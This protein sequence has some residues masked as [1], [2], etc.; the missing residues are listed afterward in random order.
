MAVIRKFRYILT[1]FFSYI[2][3]DK[4][5]LKYEI[6]RPLL[7]TNVY[8]KILGRK[9]MIWIKYI[10]YN[11]NQKSPEFRFEFKNFYFGLCSTLKLAFEGE[12]TSQN[13]LFFVHT[14]FYFT[15]VTRDIFQ[16]VFTEVLQRNRG[17]RWHTRYLRHIHTHT[18]TR[19]TIEYSSERSNERARCR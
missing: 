5:V 11:L 12:Q 19:H 8:S 6:N 14:I 2:Y 4:P 15:L 17:S 18:H 7:Y 13:L 3:N 9:I 16:S 1:I 10:I